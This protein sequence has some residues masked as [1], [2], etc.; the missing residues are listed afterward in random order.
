MPKNYLF[1]AALC[2]VKPDDTFQ[3]S[4]VEDGATTFISEVKPE[5]EMQLKTLVRVVPTALV[6]STLTEAREMALEIVQQK[7]PVKDGW[8]G[9]SVELVIMEK[10]KMLSIMPMISKGGTVETDNGA[11]KQERLM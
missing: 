10:E 2:A 9:H 8:L 5:H 3:S 1:I 11:A 4:A 7:Y 6:A